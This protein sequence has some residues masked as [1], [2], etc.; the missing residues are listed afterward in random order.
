VSVNPEVLDF[1]N[2]RIFQASALTT[3]T[4]QSKQLT[5]YVEVKPPVGAERSHQAPVATH[6]QCQLM[7]RIALECA[8]RVGLRGD[9]AAD[10]ESAFIQD[11]LVKLAYHP[12]L[13]QKLFGSPGYLFRCALNFA[14]TVAERERAYLE[15]NTSLNILTEAELEQ[16]LLD[17]V[18][19]PELPEMNVLAAAR[20][21]WLNNAL[22]RLTP[23]RRDLVVQ[24]V[25]ND[26]PL[27]AIA[28]RIGKSADSVRQEFHRVI[29]QLRRILNDSDDYAG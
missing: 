23:A 11:R 28:S 12:N 15:R 18:G 22:A 4:W 5:A 16:H 21:E 14:Y 3:I 24:H 7:R 27:N 8:Y 17:E 10:C 9:D 29:L 2:S 25:L 26:E 6:D 13:A 20:R 1:S 19:A